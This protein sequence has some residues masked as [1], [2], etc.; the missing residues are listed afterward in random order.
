MSALEGEQVTTLKEKCYL[1]KSFLK[2][3]NVGDED[4]VSSKHDAKWF[5]IV[6]CNGFLWLMVAYKKVNKFNLHLVC[7]KYDNGFE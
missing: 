6:C 1:I 2:I 3:F 7:K 5:I 4:F